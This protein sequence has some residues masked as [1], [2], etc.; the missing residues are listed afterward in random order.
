MQ[1]DTRTH[2]CAFFTRRDPMGR[3]EAVCGAWVWP[4]QHRID[5]A[6]LGCWGCRTWMENLDLIEPETANELR[7]A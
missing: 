5:P 6:E 4:E 7:S 1:V 3:Q 2:Y